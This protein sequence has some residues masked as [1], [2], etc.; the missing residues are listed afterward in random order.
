VGGRQEVHIGGCGKGGPLHEVLHA[1]GFEHEHT[2]PDRDQHI[3]VLMQNVASDCKYLFD[4]SEATPSTSYDTESVMHYASYACSGNGEP[5]MLK[6]SDGR[7]I[8]DPEA[9]SALDRAGIQALY[10]GTPGG[11]PGSTPIQPNP[12]V[13]PIPVP[14]QLPGWNP[15]QLPAL[16]A[17]PAGWAL[18]GFP[19]AS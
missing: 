10:G 7:P 3:T 1:A 13:L 9:L 5:T 4:H 11:T 17:L 14:W 6:K 18:P 16:P 12:T 19:S 8:R 15:E 2:R